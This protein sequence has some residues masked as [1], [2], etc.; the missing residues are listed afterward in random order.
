MIRVRLGLT[1][2]LLAVPSLVLASD[3]PFAEFRIPDHSW[4]SFS[5]DLYGSLGATDRS[6]AS[7][8]TDGT[9]SN[10]QL[11]T[12]HSWFRDSERIR[13]WHSVGATFDGNWLGAESSS[14]YRYSYFPEDEWWTNRSTNSQER[15]RE[16]AFA[17]TEW[18]VRP[19][20]S[21]WD[22]RLAARVDGSWQR[23]VGSSDRLDSY[24]GPTSRFDELGEYRSVNRA[25]EYFARVDL[26]VA[27]GRVRDATGVFRARLLI[28]RLRSD[29]RLEREPSPPAARRLAD[30]FYVSGGFGAAHELP[31][32]FFW[33]EVEA[34]LRED[35]V[36]GAAGFDAY[37]L[38]HGLDPLVVA[39]GRFSRQRGWQ[40][41]P[42]VRYLHTH[43]LARWTT[44]DHSR[45]SVDDSVI[46]ERDL[47]GSSRSS[48]GDDDVSAGARVEWHR[49]LD[50]RTQVDLVSEAVFGVGSPDER[51]DVSSQF[52]IGR[53]I[54]ERWFLRTSA[55]Q[56][57]HLDE[58]LG[59]T[60]DW[61]TSVDMT[62]QYF[63]EDRWSLALALSQR[64]GR[65]RFNGGPFDRST[66][67]SLGLG[68][69]RGAFDAPGLIDPVRPLN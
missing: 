1:A 36:I 69:N 13:T 56:T 30:L 48:S 63:L 40:A 6:E 15:V 7:R 47:T 43:A 57:R 34:L 5:I 14:R 41:G 31:G 9:Q 4:R 25:D 21:D 53:L 8:Q 60:R 16:S 61:F 38:L 64:Q 42:L 51:I 65:T 46:F 62:V 26:G 11:A 54:D 2:L 50:L 27:R 19:R 29:G 20:A 24:I 22:V 10:A 66:Q 17:L 33:Q 18:A 35:G 12:A 58:E 32:K 39:A 37:D 28:D 55:T 68:F 52:S 59:G 44:R 45:R 49:P 23:Q 67:L 3:D